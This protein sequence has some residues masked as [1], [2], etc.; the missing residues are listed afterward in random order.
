MTNGPLS[1]L[2]TVPHSN[3]ETKACAQLQT[4]PYPTT[5]KS[6]LNSNSYSVRT[7]L[8]AQT[9]SFKSKT[10]K[11][12]TWNFPLLCGMPRPSPTIL[13]M[14]IWEVHTIHA[15]NFSSYDQHFQVSPLQCSNFWGIHP[16]A[17]PAQLSTPYVKVT[18]WNTYKK[19]ML[20]P[21]P[22]D[23]WL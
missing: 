21:P 1:A 10:D 4:F 14:V 17:Q 23:A 19:A 6:F 11:Q 7:T 16:E 2:M 18:K 15:L 8:L 5:S 9:L 13:A 3:E 22:R 12:K 20:S